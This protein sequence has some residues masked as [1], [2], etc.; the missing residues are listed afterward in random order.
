[1]SSAPDFWYVRFPDGRVLRAAS[2][3]VVRQEVASGRIPF[4]STVRRSPSEEWVALEWTAEFADVPRPTP[5]PRETPPGRRVNDRRV[6]LFE[7]SRNAA[8]LT[9]ASRLDSDRL[10][11]VGVRGCVRELL[12][13]LDTT[14]VRT[15]LLAA[16]PVG[17]LFGVLLAALPFP[18]VD[19]AELWPGRQAVSAEISQGHALTI[20]FLTGALLLAAA[21]TTALLTRLTYVELALLRPALWKE[22]LAGLGALACRLVLAQGG[23]M[24]AVLGL[25]VLLHW[26]PLWLLPAG[27]S[28][29]A[30]P[31]NGAGIVC[32]L[33]LL[34]EVALWPLFFFAWL[35]GPILVVEQCSVG[36]GLS[37]W[38]RL[39]RRHLG[40]TFLFETLAAGIGVLLLVPLLLLLLPLFNPAPDERLHLP[41]ALTRNVLLGLA[42][43]PSLAYFVVANLF[44]YL[45]LRY[46]LAGRGQG[47]RMK[48][49]G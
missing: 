10:Q 30:G 24:A 8:P 22:G 5:P 12:S 39:L 29:A 44:V 32:V 9:V 40:R 28:G 4:T 42:L 3:Q 37:E 43:T 41:V 19:A 45:N 2:T 16:L 6:G 15:K 11:L 38:A 1:M 23:V 35:I 25:M 17:L 14:L 20:G 26:L 47:R 31:T 34:G 36:K 48:D 21:M 33:A 49:E 13:A 18:P 27:E 46:E 7:E